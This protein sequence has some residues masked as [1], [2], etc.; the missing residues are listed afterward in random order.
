M[1]LIQEL[2]IAYLIQELCINN[3][4]QKIN[5][6]PFQ[7]EEAID[8]MAQILLGQY[9]LLKHGII[10]RDLKPDNILYKLGKYKICDFGS[11]KLV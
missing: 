3:L 6:K 2:E 8:I 11:S 1:D 9:E 4:T 7:V 10:H 5:E